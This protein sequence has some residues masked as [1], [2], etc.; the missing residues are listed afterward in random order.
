MASRLSLIQLYMQAQNI[1]LTIASLFFARNVEHTNALFTR[2]SVLQP[3]GQYHRVNTATTWTPNK[4]AA[5]LKR[6]QIKIKCQKKLKS[7]LLPIIGLAKC[8][9]KLGKRI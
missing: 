4:Q 8:F 1:G 3:G 2:R 7:S 9:D 6:Y 5:T